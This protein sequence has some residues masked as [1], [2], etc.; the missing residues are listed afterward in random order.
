MCWSCG[1]NNNEFL[2]TGQLDVEA[3]TENV[4][5]WGYRGRVIRSNGG[6]PRFPRQYDILRDFFFIDDILP[7][8]QVA[9]RSTS[10]KITRRR[11]KKQHSNNNNNTGQ[12]DEED[13][14]NATTPDKEDKENRKTV[15]EQ[16]L[17]KTINEKVLLKMMIISKSSNKENQEELGRKY[18]IS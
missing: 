9:G 10:G 2:V 11:S 14:K 13:K 1:E 3:A 8:P 16:K 7:L 5:L 4:A 17:K 12:K 18:T 6:R 15:K